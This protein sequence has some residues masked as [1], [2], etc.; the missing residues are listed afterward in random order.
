MVWASASTASRS[1]LDSSEG[2][3]LRFELGR[4][5]LVLRA[6]EDV[7]L[8]APAQIDESRRLKDGLPLC[9]QQSTGNSPG[10]ELDVV[11]GV[12]RYRLVDGD[13]AYLKPPARLQYPPDLAHNRR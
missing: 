1:W 3:A 2:D 13:I 4:V 5:R 8:A 10:P 11:F 6:R 7:D 12:L 9:F